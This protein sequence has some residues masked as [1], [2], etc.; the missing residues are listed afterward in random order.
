MESVDET[1]ESQSAFDRILEGIIDDWYDN[2]SSYYVTREQIADNP[3]LAEGSE[4]LKRFH[5]E[6]GHR[7]KFAKDELDFTYG[8]RCEWKDEQIL[9]EISVNNKVPNFD[10]DE[11]RKRLTEHYA[12]NGSNKVPTPYELRAVSYTEI[13]RFRPDLDGAFSVEVHPGKA[14]IMRLA[15]WIHSKYLPRLAP[16]P[17][18]GKQLVEQF[19]VSPFRSVY[20]AVY[21]RSR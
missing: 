10:Y 16:R 2:V 3:E 21:R 13:F 5:D 1:Q 12:N 18:A 19:C 17:V 15:F 14:D 6:K 7:I 9:I 11:F 4:E 8:L 20:A